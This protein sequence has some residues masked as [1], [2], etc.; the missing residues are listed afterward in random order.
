MLDSPAKLRTVCYIQATFGTNR[1]TFIRNILH[2]R[3][4]KLDWFPSILKEENQ[5]FKHLGANVKNV[6]SLMKKK[7]NLDRFIWSFFSTICDLSLNQNIYVGFISLVTNF[8]QTQTTKNL[9]VT[10]TVLIV[11]I[12]YFFIHLLK[13]CF[14]KWI[15]KYKLK[16]EMFGGKN[17]H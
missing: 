7:G 16:T 1:F 17:L 3:W 11:S 8:Y 4:I 2:K 10:K 13:Y 6:N 15:W 9:K 14:R 12:K 5:V